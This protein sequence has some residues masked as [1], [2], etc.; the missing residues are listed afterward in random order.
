MSLRMTDNGA[1]IMGM[2]MRIETGECFSAGV[3]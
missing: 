2:G 3:C 1:V